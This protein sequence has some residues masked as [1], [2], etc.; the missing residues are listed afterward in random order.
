MGRVVKEEM[1]GL[2]TVRSNKQLF[3]PIIIPEHTPLTASGLL[4]IL[5]ATVVSISCV[6]LQN[7]I[8]LRFLRSRWRESVLRTGNTGANGWQSAL[9]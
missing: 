8:F 1:I 5:L 2:V 9:S 6:N 7:L 3:T 4:L